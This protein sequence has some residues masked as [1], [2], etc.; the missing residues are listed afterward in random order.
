[1]IKGQRKTGMKVAVA[2]LGALSF[3]LLV[4]GPCGLLEQRAFGAAY[5]FRATTNVNFGDVVVW[6]SGTSRGVRTTSAPGSD[7]VAGVAAEAVAAGNDCAIRQ[8]GGRV[9]VN[10]TG[11]VDPSVNPWLVTSGATGKAQGVGSLES[12][13]I[14]ARAITSDGTP[15]A[16]Q[17]YASVNLGFLGYGPSGVDDDIPDTDDW[18]EAQ[19]EL[20]LSDATD[21]FTDND[22]ALSDD[23][24]TLADVQSA[25]SSDF[26][27]IGGTDDDVP[28][29]SDWTEANLESS[30]SDATDVLTNNDNLD[31]L[32]DGANRLAVTVDTSFPGSPSEGGLFYH[33][34]YNIQFQ[35]DGS[36][37]KPI[38]SSGALTL[39]VDSGSGSDTAGKGYGPGANATAT[40]QYAIDNC[41]PAIIGGDVTI[42][43]A[44]GTYSEALTAKAVQRTGEYTVAVVGILTSQDTGTADADSTV[45]DLEDDGQGWTPS[46]H[47]GRL[48]II[49]SGTGSG[50]ERFIR[51]NDADTLNIAGLFATAPDA[52]STFTIYTLGTIISPGAG[53]T[54]ATLTAASHWT[55]KY[56]EFSAGAYGI[57]AEDASA[58]VTIQSCEFD[59]HTNSGIVAF[60]GSIIRPRTVYAHGAASNGIWLTE[61]GLADGIFDAYITGCNT[62]GS[63]VKGGVKI[64]NNSYAYFMRCYIDGNDKNGVYLTNNGTAEFIT[65]GN[66]SSIVN[67]GTPGEYGIRSV[68][69]SQ[70]IGATGQTFS[71]NDTDQSADAASFASHT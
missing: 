54:G 33:S 46:A 30:L 40:I 3:L 27:N 20:S 49:N 13:G 34:T 5:T 43:V 16:G 15:A 8:D 41:V 14:F 39:Y 32:A 62:S 44:A 45:T 35:H 58:N 17:V 6:D 10:V 68:Q 47:A 70:A 4:M 53:N 67:H 21:V 18:T 19:M 1:M 2:T 57:W 61:V 11:S 36:A 24:V 64:G 55:F 69:G 28:D 66:I 31:D 59:T 7:Y 71:G 60:A 12:D 63:A 38:R 56:L 50:Q 25:T 29:A 23:D 52:T 22:G 42:N 51:D 48:L 9:T 26:H 37:W 65:G